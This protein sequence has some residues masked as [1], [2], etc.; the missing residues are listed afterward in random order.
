MQCS[1]ETIYEASDFIALF[2]QSSYALR[3]QQIQV[4]GQLK[5]SLQFK[6]RSARDCQ[7][8]PEVAIV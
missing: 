3:L 6:E 1:H 4:A 5:L 8:L 2:H 7:E